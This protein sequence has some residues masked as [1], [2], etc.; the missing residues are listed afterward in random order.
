MT[1]KNSLLLTGGGAR[2]AY[3]VG[4]LKSI[5]DYHSNTLKY[6]GKIFNIFSG[7]S[8]GAINSVAMASH[9]DNPQEAINNL[10]HFW[11]NMKVE[12]IYETEYQ[13]H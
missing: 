4:V 1:L 2:A 13:H 7:V 3:Q 5:Q 9:N 6:H 8:A 11:T 10:H 12:N